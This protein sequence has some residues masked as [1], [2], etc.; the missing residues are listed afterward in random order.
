MLATIKLSK[1][2]SDTS[3][4]SLKEIKSKIFNL[5]TKERSEYK[6]AQNQD[7]HEKVLIHILKI[8]KEA[9][10]NDGYQTI[11]ED[12]CTLETFKKKW[13]KKIPMITETKGHSG[14]KWSI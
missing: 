14:P 5:E 4:F 13:Y 6:S 2:S 12:W 3:D 8:K 1:T 9:C 7:L 11:S 10:S